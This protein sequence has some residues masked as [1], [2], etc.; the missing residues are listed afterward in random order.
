MRASP[1][2]LLPAFAAA[3]FAA[4]RGPGPPPARAPRLRRRGRGGD[5]RGVRRVAARHHARRHSA[6]ARRPGPGP[7]AGRP[8]LPP[9]RGRR[10][11]RR[12]APAP[13]RRRRADGRRAPG[14]RPRPPPRFG[15]AA[16]FRG[17]R[18]RLLRRARGA[19]GELSC[20][21]AK[22][23]PASTSWSR[24]ARSSPARARASSSGHF[25]RPS[26]SPPRGARGRPPP[27]RLGTPGT[28]ARPRCLG[29]P[30][31]RVRRLRPARPGHGAAP[32]R[33]PLPGT[34]RSSRSATRPT[35]TSPSAVTRCSS[36]KTAPSPRLF[37]TLTRAR[38][39]RTSSPRSPSR[40]AASSRWD[41][42][43]GGCSASSSGIPPS[44]S[45]SSSR[46]RSPFPSSATGCRART[47]VPSWTRA[48]TSCPTTRA[49][50][51]PARAG[52]G[53]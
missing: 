2:S 28:A 17:A 52:R 26:R 32:L 43:S 16:P 50:S 33:G 44:A 24:S 45:T 5:R 35:R 8:P 1:S 11:G 38:R 53:T 21:P 34:H 4:H 14:T 15:L 40:R 20:P 49:G 3:G 27:P 37:P 41:R 42:S 10:R 39:S 19:R 48:S 9:R 22:R 25:S 51:F 46:T 47:F 18:R 30:R 23:S 6:A 29:P 36:G 7:L 31:P 13:P 12:R